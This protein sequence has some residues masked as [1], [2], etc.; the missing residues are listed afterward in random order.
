MLSR[1]PYNAFFRFLFNNEAGEIID[2]YLS[3]IRSGDNEIMRR[4]IQTNKEE[5]ERETYTKRI[6]RSKKF[7]FYKIFK[8]K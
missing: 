2:N 8:R 7:S 1:F 4:S 6:L 5:I 3:A